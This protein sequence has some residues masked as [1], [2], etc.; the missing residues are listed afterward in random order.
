M[1]AHHYPFIDLAVHASVR[2]HFAKG[3]AVAVLSR[4]LGEVLWANGAAAQLFGFS[5]IYDVLDEGLGRQSSMRRQIESAVSGL[6]RT[7]RP[8]NF[9]VRSA[10]G[11]SR[12][13]APANLEKIVLPDG[14]QALL[15]TSSQAGQLLAPGARAR[16][17]IAGFEG[18]GTHVAVLDERGQVLAA[19]STFNEIGL[20]K[21]DIERMVADVADARD[22]LVKRM[23]DAPN[24]AMPTAIGRL[25]DDPALNLLFAVEQAPVDDTVVAATVLDVVGHHP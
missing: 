10:S 5:N 6:S 25:A 19:S 20:A 11:F 12:V 23:T 21:A 1:P 16:Q 3:D 2:D 17:I 7:G 14:A 18:T 9:M 4:D 13:M 8:Q 22:R 15:L 24:G